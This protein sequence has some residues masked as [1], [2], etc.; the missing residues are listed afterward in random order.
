MKRD[1]IKRNHQTEYVGSIEDAARYAREMK[2]FAWLFYRHD[3]KKVVELD[4]PGRYLEA[5]SGPGI[6]AAMVAKARPSV[7]IV[8]LDVSQEMVGVGRDYIHEQGLSDRI[9]FVVGDVSD[10]ATVRSL[11]EFNLVYST[12]SM[13]HWQAI[14]PALSNLWQAVKPGGTL[15]LADFRRVWWVGL[16]PFGGGLIESIKISLTPEELDHLARMAHMTS[17]TVETRFPWFV[18][19]TAFRSQ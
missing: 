17:Y 8:C 2:R 15:Y 16:I 12:Y 19:L 13:H 10:E 3:F 4:A 11:G 6:L 14:E 9:E 5:A 18:S 7:R 1:S